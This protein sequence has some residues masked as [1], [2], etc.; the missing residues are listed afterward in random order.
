VLVPI[1][2]I[3]WNASELQR[4]RSGDMKRSTLLEHRFIPLTP[5]Q[6]FVTSWL[7]LAS[8]NH[9]TIS[10]SQSHDDS[11][12]KHLSDIELG[13]SMWKQL[14]TCRDSDSHIRAKANSRLQKATD[15]PPVVASS[16]RSLK[17]NVKRSNCPLESKAFV[18]TRQ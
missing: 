10:V 1:F 4:T 15:F 9:S 12:R 8:Q 18:N 14:H 13:Q 7:I 17:L 3:I 6:E 5:K 2:R 11:E 16:F